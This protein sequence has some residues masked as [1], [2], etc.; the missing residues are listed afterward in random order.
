MAGIVFNV[1]QNATFRR[2]FYLKSGGLPLDITGALVYMQVRDINGNLL[3]DLSV[4]DG[5]T[6]TGPEGKI[7]LVISEA[8][9]KTNA[10]NGNTDLFIKFLAADQIKLFA[11]PWN[12]TKAVTTTP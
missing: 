9:M 8:E 1:D 10:L 6:V 12:V 3:H 11:G 7:E 2:I 4:G 5:I